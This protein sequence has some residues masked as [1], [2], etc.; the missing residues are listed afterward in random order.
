MKVVVVGKGGRE[1]ALAQKLK[2][3]SSVTDLWVCPGN[4]GMSL[5]GLQC[6]DVETTEE[7]ERFCLQNAVNLVVVG[8]EA[9]ILS[10]LKQ[11]L[12]SQGI[13]CFAPSAKVAALES[14]KLFCKGIL[15]D[16]GVPTAA[17]LVGY[18]EKEA[19]QFIQ[20]HD[21]TQP[22]VVKADGLAQ[23]KGVWVCESLA[24][25]RE[26]VQVL[27]SQYGFPLLLEECLVGKELSAFALCDGKDFVLL[28]TACDYKRITPDP[29][30]ANTG[31]MGAYSPCDFITP[32]DEKTLRE[33]F[34][35]TL[36]CL[37]SKNL[38]YQGFLFAGLMKTSEGLFVLEYNVRLGDPETQALLP[39]LKT[40][41]AQ[42]IVAAV[43]H[44]LQNQVC[45]LKPEV[46]VH[47]VAVSEGYPQGPLNTG[48]PVAIQSRVLQ[49]LY[50]AGVCE[51]QNALVNSG[52]RV[53][54]VTA[55]GSSKEQAR[56]L[57]Y[58]DI[59]KVSFKGMYVR[60]D[61]GL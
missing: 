8:P 54:G 32:E 27:G 5:T 9:S 35:K 30:S 47:V 59:H 1:H 16:A 24:K 53:L 20:Q 50:Y 33:F 49:Q 34:A 60:E 37:H 58:Q 26:A 11:R 29:F 38:S 56:V 14:S 40:D 10:D 19:L 15:K 46:S 52:G 23:G 22:L 43:T 57:A 4:P 45:E 55:L 39:R 7:I 44:N 25:A 18:S 2:E 12:Q 48:H 17:C 3:S 51:K 42:L 61:I 13:S 41:L 36:A 21:F 31:G 28:G 6:A